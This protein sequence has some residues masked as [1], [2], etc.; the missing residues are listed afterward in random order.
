[1]PKTSEVHIKTPILACMFPG[2]ILK[3]FKN[4]CLNNLKIDWLDHL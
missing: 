4:V 2:I 3:P 1:M